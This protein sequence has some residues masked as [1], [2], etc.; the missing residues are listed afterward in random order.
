MNQKFQNL[1]T[2]CLNSPSGQY[3]KYV[4]TAATAR[5][6][7]ALADAL[8]GQNSQVNFYGMDYGATLGSYFVNS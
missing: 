2:A 6:L 1:G 4:G 7:A 3:L 5:D 8:D